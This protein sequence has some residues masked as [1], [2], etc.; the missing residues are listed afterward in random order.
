MLAWSIMFGRVLVIIGI[1]NTPLLAPILIA[2]LA[3]ASMAG[4]YGLYLQRNSDTEEDVP[5]R[6][7]NPFSLG[8]ALAFGVLYALLLVAARAAQIYLG[9]AGIF[10]SAFVSGL[11]TVDAITVI[12]A[13][14]SASGRLA[15]D[16]AAQAIVL[17]TMA[18]TLAKGAIVAFTGSRELRR[19]ILPGMLLVIAVGVAVTFLV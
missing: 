7:N 8:Q 3:S 13:D 5:S 18:N 4:I 12:I 17:A 16:T 6:I 14:L 2:M 1:W 19:L 9:D 10:L 11:A 15:L